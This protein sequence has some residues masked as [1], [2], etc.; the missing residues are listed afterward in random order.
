MPSPFTLILPAYQQPLMLQRQIQEFNEY[1]PD[2]HVI[3]VDDGSPEPAEPVVRAHASPSLLQ[4]L[5]LYA[6]LVDVPW[7]RGMCR[8][9]GAVE[10]RTEFIV[11][12]DIDHILPV[13]CVKALL[14]F[15]PD[16]KSWY[17]FS[18]WRRGKADETRQKDALPRNCEYGQVKP[19][20]DSFLIR[21]SLFLESY[22]D[23][24]YSGALGGGTPFLARM[25]QLASVL[26]LPE[27]IRL[28]VYTRHVITDASITTLSRDT[29]EYSRRR[30]QREKSGDTHPGEM[31]RLPW[32]QV[33]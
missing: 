9:L 19:H 4:H 18:R 12:L 17:R 16:E 10:A 33:L 21:R 2:V 11:E 7:N 13:A 3:I 15:E 32:K 6:V 1:P 27:A 8:N 29:S 25:E 5:R 28:E 31:L 22:Y 23:E 30:K 24:S 14:D 26:L 20:G